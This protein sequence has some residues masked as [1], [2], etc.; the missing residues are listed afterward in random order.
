MAGKVQAGH[1][2]LGRMQ[3]QQ[4]VQGRVLS[5]V[6]REQQFKQEF[7]QHRWNDQ[8]QH[9]YKQEPLIRVGNKGTLGA[10]VTAVIGPVSKPQVKP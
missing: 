1:N 10:A 5:L 2:G 7:W 9:N 8:Q 6:L 3:Q 4:D